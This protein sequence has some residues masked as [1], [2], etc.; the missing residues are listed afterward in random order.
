[1]SGGRELWVGRIKKSCKLIDR[2][3]FQDSQIIKLISEGGINMLF[4]QAVGVWIILL[5]AAIINGTLRQKFISTL[6]DELPAHLV[7]T[8][9]LAV[10]IFI[11]SS[12]FI[13]AKG[14]TKRSTLFLI[15]GLWVVL[16]IAFEFLFFHYATGVPWSKLLA[17]YNILKGRIFVLVLLSSLLSPLIASRLFVKR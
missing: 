8:I 15:G 3:I 2:G 16:T 4:M 1:M 5:I 14:I 10:I 12:L 17:D 6:L 13:R 7:S 9:L 11:V